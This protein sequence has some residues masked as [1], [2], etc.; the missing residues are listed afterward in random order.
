MKPGGR[1]QAAIEVLEDILSHHRPA[2]VALSDWGR[3]HRFAGSGDRAA[4]GNLVYDALRVKNASAALMDAETPRAM[5]LGALALVAQQSP[6]EIAATVDGSQHAP[7]A[8]TDDERAMLS[9]RKGLEHAP[10]YVQANVPEWLWPAFTEMF[11]DEAVMEGQALAERAPVD[12]R[13]NTLK[14]SVEK[15][16]KALARAGAEPCQ[17]ASNGL[18]IAPPGPAG[19]TPNVQNEPGYQK[20]WFEIQDEGSQIVSQLV[21]AKPGEQI[22]DYCAGGGGKTLALAADMENKGQIFAYDSDKSRLAPIHQRLKRAGARN[23]QVRTPSGDGPAK[24]LAD[25][26]GKMDRV[27]IDA[28]CTGTGVWRRRPDAKWKQTPEALEARQEEQRQILADARNYVR[29]GGYLCYITCSLL[30]VENEHQIHQFIENNPDF[31][32]VSAEEVWRELYGFDKPS[33]WSDDMASLRL[34]P[35]STGT[36][37]FYFA[38]LERR[39]E[40]I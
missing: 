38:V 7:D 12:L 29:P 39:V 2:S 8:L 3:T 10:E 31:E 1:V 16:H 6:D 4:I 17:I 13:V 33:P 25:L 14:S 26:V 19:R 34:T 24:D 15:V 36:D 28:P 5:V 32:L 18:R 20:G 11:E 40:E 35:A 22:L 23:V 37:G 21:F 27:V 9:T 30:P